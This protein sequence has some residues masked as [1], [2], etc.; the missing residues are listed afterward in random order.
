M[1]DLLQKNW[2]L[3]WRI[4]NNAE[5]DLQQITKIAFAKFY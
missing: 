3:T 5:N 2:I 4:F 1:N